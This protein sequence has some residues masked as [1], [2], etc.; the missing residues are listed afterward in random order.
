M[1]TNYNKVLAQKTF[2]EEP[3]K[4]CYLSRKRHVLNF[5]VGLMFFVFAIL[6][7]SYCY[8]K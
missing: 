5:V 1:Q 8:I 4:A 3:V 6:F 2:Q 7:L